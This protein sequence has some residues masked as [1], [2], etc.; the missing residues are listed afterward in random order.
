M[1]K[2]YNDNNPMK[3][4]QILVLGPT[5]PFEIKIDCG[6][7]EVLSQKTKRLLPQT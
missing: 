1:H 6:K 4:V 5:G 2:Y 7:H 3:Q